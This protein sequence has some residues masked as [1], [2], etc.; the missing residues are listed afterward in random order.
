M[1]PSLPLPSEKGTSK[2]W[3]KDFFLKHGSSQNAAVTVLCVPSSLVTVL[4]VPSSL[5]TVL[6][7]ASSL[8][9]VL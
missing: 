9:T 6:C 5:V 3:S 4:C 1:H 8:V 2:K 7:V